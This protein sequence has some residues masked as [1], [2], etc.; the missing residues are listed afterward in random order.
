MCFAAAI[1]SWYDRIHWNNR[2]HRFASQLPVLRWNGT[3]IGKDL[4]STY[5]VREGSHRSPL[6]HSWEDDFPLRW[7]MYGFQEGKV[8][9]RY[10]MYQGW[11]C[12]FDAYLQLLVRLK[13]A[14]VF[15]HPRVTIV[16]IWSDSDDRQR[17]VHNEIHFDYANLCSSSTSFCIL[18]VV[19][20]SDKKR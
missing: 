7:D 3:S 11:V 17:P 15:A 5:L 18:V 9:W 8:V 12:H 6:K 19:L 13:F 4:T 14:G 16:K 2:T 1:F 20:G 10:I